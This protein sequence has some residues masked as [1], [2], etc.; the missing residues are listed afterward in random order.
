LFNNQ[1]M[2]FYAPATLVRDAKR[3]GVQ[4]RPVC[5]A[6]SNWECL[7]EPDDS[8]RLGLLQVQGFRR[9]PALAMLQERAR[10]PFASLNDFK[11]RT[12]FSKPEL[13]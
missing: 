12:H 9:E 5:V 4:I 3:H 1:P 10:Q 2:G 13:R 11:A 7:I 8:I 6:R